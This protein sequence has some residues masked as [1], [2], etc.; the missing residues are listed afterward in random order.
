MIYTK[1]LKIET[2]FTK[3]FT[4]IITLVI[5]YSFCENTN[6]YLFF[7]INAQ[8]SSLKYTKDYL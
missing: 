2:N 8:D 5:F 4:K 6:F 3:K 7:I 1:F